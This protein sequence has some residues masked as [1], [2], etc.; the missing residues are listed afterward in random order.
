MLLMRDKYLFLLNQP[1]TVNGAI[2]QGIR[3]FY[4]DGVLLKY[5]LCKA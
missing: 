5:V 3:V 2:L 1:K 4:V